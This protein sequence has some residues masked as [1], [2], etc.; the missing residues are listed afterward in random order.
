M[1]LNEIYSTDQVGTHLSDMF[2]INNHLKQGDAFITI[3]LQLCS[4]YTISKVQAKL[5]GL[6]LNRT[7]RLLVYANDV[8]IMSGS[9]HTIQK[10]QKL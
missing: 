7:R 2:P 6:K 3:A 10:T 8:N 4:K 5:D 9:I 1:C